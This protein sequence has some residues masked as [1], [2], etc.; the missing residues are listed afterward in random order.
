M[1]EENQQVK[2]TSHSSL[3]GQVAIIT[4]ASSGIG[5]A[6]AIVLAQKGTHVSLVA[7]REKELRDTAKKC[8]KG[9][10]AIC[11]DVR[12]AADVRR[13]VERTLGKFGKIDVLVNSAGILISGPLD[14]ATDRRVQDLLETNLLGTVLFCKSV[15][16]V[17]KRQKRGHIV[18][19]SSIAGTRPQVEMAVYTASKFGVT[20]FSDSLQLEVKSYG[21]KVSTIRP[22]T[23]ATDL[24][25]EV[26]E[27]VHLLKPEDVARSVVFILEQ[28]DH[29]ILRD[30]FL[31]PRL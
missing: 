15:L 26:R 25:N 10:L 24:W 17:M 23:V 27:A 30:L 9:A 19:V 13:A 5:C 3:Q 4:G 20:G 1:G 12:K 2:A 28:P 7:R 8:G 14:Q 29:V 11:A 31:H 18:N 22:G 16:P 21:I 6:I